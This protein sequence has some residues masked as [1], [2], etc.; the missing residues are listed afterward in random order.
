MKSVH[1]HDSKLKFVKT[2]LFHSVHE[3]EAPTAF[4]CFAFIC[5]RAYPKQGSLYKIKRAKILS[6]SPQ[7]A[8]NH[9]MTI[10]YC[11]VLN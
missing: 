9:V 7:L 10:A 2:L 11:F 3:N 4:Y 8:L 6:E 1:F 5:G